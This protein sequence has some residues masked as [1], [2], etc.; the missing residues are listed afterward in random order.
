MHSQVRKGLQLRV[1]S[2]PPPKAVR[3]LCSE[4]LSAALTLEPTAMGKRLLPTIPCP[5]LFSPSLAPRP[6]VAADLEAA[7]LGMT[8]PPIRF[9]SWVAKHLHINSVQ[10]KAIAFGGSLSATSSSFRISTDFRLA[11]GSSQC[12]EDPA[13]GALLHSEGECLATRLAVG[14]GAQTLPVPGAT[15]NMSLQVDGTCMLE[16]FPTFSHLL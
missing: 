5:H 7:C 3:F 12:A 4:R 14:L 11:T 16:L 10:F 13:S 9:G 1:I 8:L 15:L 6:G 2:D